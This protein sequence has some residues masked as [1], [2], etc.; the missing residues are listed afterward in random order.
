MTGQAQRMLRSVVAV[1]LLMGCWPAAGATSD[2]DYSWSVFTGKFTAD[3]FLD[4]I[5]TFTHRINFESAWVTVVN[6]NHVL[7]RPTSS[8]RWEGE[9]QFGVH[10]SGPQDHVEFNAAIAHRWSDWPWDGLLNTSFAIGTGLSLASKPP[11][12]EVEGEPGDD[13]QRLLLYLLLEF[14]VAPYWAERWSIFCRIHH[15]S[16][17]FGTFGG[18]HGGSDHIG[19]GFRWFMSTKS[20]AG[21]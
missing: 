9:L 14:E 13:A 20:G 5:L 8:R 1:M 2:H 4:D 15:R 21:S 18:V 3:R 17:A 19:V 11:L 6:Y 10:H 16:G 7:A 12:L